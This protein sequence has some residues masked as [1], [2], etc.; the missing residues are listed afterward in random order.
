MKYTNKANLPQEIVDAVTKDPYTRGDAD[1]S[2]TGLLAPV[3][4]T[5]LMRRHAEDI[6]VDVS[7]RL[8]A[9]YGSLGHKLIEQ[10]GSAGITERRLS[11]ICDGWKLSGATDL[12]KDG[13][14]YDYK[15]CSTFVDTMGGADTKPEWGQQLNMYAYLWLSAGYKVEALS[16]VA[17]FRDWQKSKARYSRDYPQTPVKVYDIPLWDKSAALEFIAAR[18]GTIL[19]ALEKADD[20][21]PHCTE[22]ERW[23]RPSKYAVMKNKTA[24]R[25]TKLYDDELPAKEHADRLGKDAIIVYRPGLNVRCEDYCDCSEFCHQYKAIKEAADAT[26]L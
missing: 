6:E 12:Y 21:L 24:K 25:A 11:I 15:Y 17:L 18:I 7:S 26:D 9:L 22:A 20:K 23:A 5:V 16:I 10:S 13:H 8:Y 1:I 4:Q 14:I 2:V 19:D 3:Q